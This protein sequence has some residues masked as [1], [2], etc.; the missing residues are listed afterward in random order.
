M[1]VVC[2][3]IGFKICPYCFS[4]HPYDMNVSEY[5]QGK[6]AFRDG[7]PC[8]LIACMFLVIIIKWLVVV[9]VKSFKR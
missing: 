5:L 7:F 3:C 6:L 2:G 8:N 4:R 9:C 1:T